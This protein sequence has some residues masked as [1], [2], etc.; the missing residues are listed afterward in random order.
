MRTKANNTLNNTVKLTEEQ[1]EIIKRYTRHSQHIAEQIKAVPDPG[2]KAAEMI[3]IGDIFKSR[4]KKEREFRLPELPQ[5]PLNEWDTWS[6]DLKGHTPDEIRERLTTRP[7][8]ETCITYLCR[9]TQIPEDF[10]EEFMALTT[11]LFHAEGFEHLSAKQPLVY[12]EENIDRVIKI[13][14][15]D[16]KA[17]EFTDEE[18][19][20]IAQELGVGR[21]GIHDRIDW[22]YI[23]M[24]QH[25]SLDF[26]NQYFAKL[27]QYGSPQYLTN[28]AKTLARE[29][30]MMADD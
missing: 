26:W 30:L 9:F 10:F 12:N 28:V 17:E 20:T 13:C 1:I 16:N 18:L 25:Y 24:F 2:A 3:P 8:D 7:I 29:R 19:K 14:R 15:F 27:E 4:R 6:L 5:I 11:G 21:A 23:C 22:R